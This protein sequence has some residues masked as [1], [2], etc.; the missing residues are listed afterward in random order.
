M[1]R[2][3]RVA[4]ARA[5]ACDTAKH[6]Q[7]QLA[8]IDHLAKAYDVP[9][10][11]MPALPVIPALPGEDWVNF[12]RDMGPLRE[13]VKPAQPAPNATQAMA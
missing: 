10:D 12:L 2:R 4:Y 8:R 3:K 1:A 7:Q 11:P 6:L 9:V 13:P 5:Q